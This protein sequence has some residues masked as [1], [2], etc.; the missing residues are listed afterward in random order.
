MII[1]AEM[2]RKDLYLAQIDF[3][4]GSGSVARDL[5]LSSMTAMGISTTVT[6]LA[7]NIYTGNSSKFSLTGGDIRIIP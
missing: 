7:R 1:H 2:H 5:I 4:N 6:S 3:S